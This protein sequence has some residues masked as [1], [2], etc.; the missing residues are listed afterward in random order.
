MVSYRYLGSALT[1]ANGVATFDYEGTGAGE[2]DVIASLDKPIVDGSIVS[3]IYAVFDTIFYD[4]GLSGTQTKWD[5]LLSSKSIESNGTKFL[6]T[7]TNASSRASMNPVD[8]ASAYDFQP[9]PMVF[10]FEVVD[11]YLPNGGQVAPQFIQQNPTVNKQIPLNS[12]YIGHTIQIRYNGTEIRLY[13]DGSDTGRY[14]TCTFDQIMRVGFSFYMKD[15]YI[16]VKNVKAY[17]I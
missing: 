3:E 10:E 13:K 6:V 16:I 8:N 15:S 12:T 5:T 9:Q 14:V 4:D 7:D 11:L 1:N 17:P 2:I